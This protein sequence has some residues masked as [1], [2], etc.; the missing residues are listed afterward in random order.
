[1]PVV[2]VSTR[3]GG[4]GQGVVVPRTGAPLPSPKAP[5]LRLYGS[6]SS[7]LTRA[8]QQ[9]PKVGVARARIGAA[10][11]GVR[12]AK[13]GRKPDFTAGVSYSPVSDDGLAPSANGR[14]QFMGKR[15]EPA[16]LTAAQ[17]KDLRKVAKS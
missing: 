7:L 1:M 11:S 14:D 10:Q 4:T 8:S 6:L 3:S 15:G 13:L 5:S 17:I 2:E 16:L 12:L 9:H